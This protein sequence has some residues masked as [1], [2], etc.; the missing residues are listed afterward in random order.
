MKENTGKRTVFIYDNM[1]ELAVKV[2]MA[3]ALG[4][5]DDY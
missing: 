2:L 3:S 4:V 5:S 1:L